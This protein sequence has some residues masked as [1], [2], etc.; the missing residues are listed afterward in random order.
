[1]K[2]ILD[3]AAAVS[4]EQAGENVRRLDSRKAASK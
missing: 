4:A 2:K 3:S 1:M